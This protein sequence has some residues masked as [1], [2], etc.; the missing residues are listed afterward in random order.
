MENPQTTDSTAQNQPLNNA[1][2]GNAAAISRNA[3]ITKIKQKFLPGFRITLLLSLAIY[4]A[5]L[6][7]GILGVHKCPVEEN[8]PLFLIATG[9][10]GLITKILTYAR[11]RLLRHFQVKF[12]ESSLYTVEIVFL[13]LGAYWVY[14]E[15]PP[16][17]DP[18]VTFY[19]QKTAYLFAFVYI[20]VVLVIIGLGVLAGLICVMCC[21]ICV[22]SL[23]SCLLNCD[24]EGQKNEDN[25]K[26]GD[27][28]QEEKALKDDDK[29][30]E[31]EK[32]GTSND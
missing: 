28:E 11:E 6:V 8:I 3:R 5:M 27:D 19:C 9:A 16:N 25:E 31:K 22:A 23:S 29:D 4:I 24:I 30:K 26:D 17:Y 1:E 2:D 14:K 10:I 21:A 32:E 12:V 15:Y 7:I 20:T 13:I 18:G